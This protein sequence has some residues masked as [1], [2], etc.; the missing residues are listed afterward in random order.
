MLLTFLERQ[1]ICLV[2]HM[3]GWLDERRIYNAKAFTQRVAKV[4]IP[5][6]DQNA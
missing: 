6:Y 5:D 1:A 2:T 3:H 4:L